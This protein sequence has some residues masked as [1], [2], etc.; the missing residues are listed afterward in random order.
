MGRHL[1]FV[2]LEPYT[3]GAMLG[4]KP[5]F[6]PLGTKLVERIIGAER[7]LKKHVAD[8]DFDLA[9]LAHERAAKPLFA[10]LGTKSM[11]GKGW[12]L[13]QPRP[14]RQSLIFF[15]PANAELSG[16]DVKTRNGG[17]AGTRNLSAFRSLHVQPIA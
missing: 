10:P 8:L 13:G 11:V 4:T 7:C 3:E 1:S 5:L 12:A 6:G 16:R 14:L 2:T 9:C 17:M 15:T